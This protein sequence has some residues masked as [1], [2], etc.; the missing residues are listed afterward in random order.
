MSLAHLL[1]S[2]TTPCDLDSPVGFSPVRCIV[3][4]ASP[5]QRRFAGD[6]AFYTFLCHAEVRTE[7]LWVSAHAHDAHACDDNDAC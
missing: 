4:L 6:T 2:P 7:P 5:S 1:A 3:E